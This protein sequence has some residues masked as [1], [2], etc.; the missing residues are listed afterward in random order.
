MIINKVRQN[1]KA[2]INYIQNI[3][4]WLEQNLAPGRCW[5]TGH[6]TRSPQL[7][8]S[9][10]STSAPHIYSNYVQ[11]MLQPSAPPL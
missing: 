2:Q 10:Q 3:D 6:L 4:F 5:D 11:P 7:L 1:E 9:V 8:N